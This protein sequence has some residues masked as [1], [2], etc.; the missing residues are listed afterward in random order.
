VIALVPWIADFLSGARLPGGIEV[1]LRTVERRQKLNEEAAAQLRFI[2]DGFQTRDEC[3]HLLNIRNNVE[4]EMK[5]DAPNALAAEFR[6]LRALGLIEGVW[7]EGSSA[8]D[9]RRRRTGDTFRRHAARRRMPG[10]AKAARGSRRP[11]CIGGCPTLPAQGTVGICRKVDQV[12]KG[13][14][15]AICDSGPL[16]WKR[17]V[18]PEL[19]PPVLRAAGLFNAERAEVRRARREN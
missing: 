4:S 7:L 11:T 9:G 2:V 13:G 6:R 8:P 10:R 14:E 18:G 1:A 5:R 12:L 15:S 3:Q 19:A 16:W 17:A